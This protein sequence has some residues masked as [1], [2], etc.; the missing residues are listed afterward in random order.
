MS[1]VNYK[2]LDLPHDVL[3][4]TYQQQQLIK[5]SRM[6]KRSYLQRVK[7]CQYA[8]KIIYFCQFIICNASLAYPP[9]NLHSTCRFSF[10]WTS[11]Q[12]GNI[13]WLF[14]KW[15]HKNQLDWN[16]INITFCSKRKT[17]KKIIPRFT[18][19]IFFQ[20]VLSLYNKTNNVCLGIPG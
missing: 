3:S 9:S 2:N 19:T 4:L 20:N 8:P 11:A 12:L 14:I 16:I 10:A 18:K 17:K 6:F 5:M 15:F 1:L 7:V 13:L